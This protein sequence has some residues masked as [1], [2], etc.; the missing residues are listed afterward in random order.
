[1]LFNEYEL[2]GF[3]KCHWTTYSNHNYGIIELNNFPDRWWH[4]SLLCHCYC[5]HSR[6]CIFQ[7]VWHMWRKWRTFLCSGVWNKCYLE[8]RGICS[9]TFI[10]VNIPWK[11]EQCVLS[12]VRNY[13]FTFSRSRH[14][15]YHNHV[16]GK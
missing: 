14:W 11:S 7:L 8:I 2:F 4:Y 13:F 10:H 15:T 1:M 3:T 16:P 9:R 6:P 5:H 12:R